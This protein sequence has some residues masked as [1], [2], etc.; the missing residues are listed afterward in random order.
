MTIWLILSGFVS[1]I[2]GGMGMGGGTLLVPLLSF[3]DLPQKTI[4]AVNLISFLPMSI[5]ALLIHAKNRLVKTEKLGWLSLPAIIFAIAS[6][7]MTTLVD[8]HLL[9]VLFGVFLLCCGLFQLKRALS[10]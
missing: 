7:F 5:F 6:S 2:I 1:G 8:N 10:N 9:R 4:Q 3:F